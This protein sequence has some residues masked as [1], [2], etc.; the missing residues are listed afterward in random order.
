MIVSH[1]HKFIYIKA[2]KV[3][4]TSTE[5]LLEKYCGLDDIVTPIKP[6]V[7][8]HEARNYQKGNFKNHRPA[9]YILKNIGH[10][11]FNEYHKVMNV[12]NPWDRVVSMYYMKNQHVSF[13][14][15]VKSGTK[16][17]DSLYHYCAINKKS[18]LDS[19]IR[20]ENLFDDTIFFMKSHFPSSNF[21]K[22]QYPRAKTEHSHRPCFRSHYSE[23]TMNIINDRYLNDIDCFGY[24]FEE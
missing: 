12:R 20:F 10:D 3:A 8:G 21:S 9:K 4:G 16:D 1:K 6:K 23:E 18:C 17:V 24:E 14:D 13:E 7:E 19:V 2:G 5:L 22:I 15:Y 11:I